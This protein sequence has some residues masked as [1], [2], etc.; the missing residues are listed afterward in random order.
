MIINGT[1]FIGSYIGCKGKFMTRR[2]GCSNRRCI[3]AGHYVVHG[4]GDWRGIDRDH[5]P[6]R[7]IIIWRNAKSSARIGLKFP[8]TLIC[9]LSGWSNQSNRQV[10]RLAGY[11]RRRQIDS[12]RAG[13]S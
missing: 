9:S 12:R 8:K 7:R 3:D 4:E 2:T 13:H 11:N 10:D 5:N 1:S 6:K